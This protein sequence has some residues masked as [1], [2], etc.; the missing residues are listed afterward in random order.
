MP[1]TSPDFYPTVPEIQ[2][3]TEE[4]AREKCS[5]AARIVAGPVVTEDTSL[6]FGALGPLPGPYIKWFLAE[7][8]HVGLNALLAGFEDKSATARCTFAYT[9][10]PGAEVHVFEG[11]CE[12]RIVA[13]RGSTH[14]GWDAIF[15]STELGK[16]FGEATKEEKATVSHRY[17][18]LSKLRT[19]L[20]SIA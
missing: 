19:Y 12:G 5:A 3:T 13:P 1:S 14:F 7:L 9:H 17:R 20:E 8:G 4:I 10:G 15:E 11:T 18:S 2:G 6:S 16:T